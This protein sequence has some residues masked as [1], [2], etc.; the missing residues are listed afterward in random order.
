MFSKPRFLNPTLILIL[1]LGLGACASFSAPQNTPTP[2]IP[3]AT[4]IPPTATPPPSV[5]AVNGEYIL[6]SEFESELARYKSAQA[7]L[8]INVTEEDANRIVLEDMIAQVLLAQSA[9]AENFQVTD[10][11][12]Q[13]RI[14][15]LADQ[16]G[17][18]DSL[19]AWQ[20]SHG[21][22]Q[23]TFQIALK[24]SVEAAWMRDR[25][26]ANVPKTTEQIHLRQIL[27]YNEINAQAAY[28]QLS[29][30]ADFDELAALYDP[31]TLGELGWVPQG[32]LLDANAD[33]AVFALQAGQYSE[34]IATEAGFHIFKAIERGEQSLSPDALMVMQEATL[35]RWI[36]EK[37]A[38]GNIVLAP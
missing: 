13:A 31:I 1:A 22:D 17:G 7:A 33:S 27:T 6:I 18:A 36:D 16:I 23:T 34:V 35:K 4:P 32:Y 24:R 37:R 25:I 3:T 38:T 14:S 20:S 29:A 26:I 8:G 21:Y 2:A 30:G 19:S 12:L 5:A 15:A 11:D 9:R 28:Q 10:S